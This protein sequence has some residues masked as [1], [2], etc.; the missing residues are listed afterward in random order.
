M[1][2]TGRFERVVAEARARLGLSNA[3]APNHVEQLVDAL[4]KGSFADIVQ[5]IAP[6]ERGV[7]KPRKFSDVR[8]YS[9][10]EWKNAKAA[11]IDHTSK[12]DARLEVT[13]LEQ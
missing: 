1:K 6:V 5:Q 3:I 9:D 2:L 13:A 12:R 4:D 8:P 7:M 11:P 10:E